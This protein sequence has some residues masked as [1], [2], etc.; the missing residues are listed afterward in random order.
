[1]PNRFESHLAASASWVSPASRN[2]TR[3]VRRNRLTNTPRGF[4]A[5]RMKSARMEAESHHADAVRYHLAGVREA[6]MQAAP[7]P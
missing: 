6:R 5:F 2:M 4:A 7:L 3:L 1:M